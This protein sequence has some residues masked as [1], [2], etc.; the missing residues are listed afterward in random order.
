[1]ELVSSNGTTLQGPSSLSSRERV[2]ETTDFVIIN[3]QG[4]SS[5]YDEPDF[6][7]FS[8]LSQADAVAQVKELLQQREM[9]QSK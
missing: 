7:L 3:G 2:S 5:S 6:D 1:M 4:N 9:L 8:S